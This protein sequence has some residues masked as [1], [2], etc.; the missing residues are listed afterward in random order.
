MGAYKHVSLHRA[1]SAVQHYAQV[2]QVT[3]GTGQYNMCKI[4]FKQSGSEI[5]A[6]K[7][8]ALPRVLSRKCD[9][10]HPSERTQEQQ[11]QTTVKYLC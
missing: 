4:I 11:K 10:R 1:C 6:L 7:K 8:N 2:G 9:Y 5:M 3:S